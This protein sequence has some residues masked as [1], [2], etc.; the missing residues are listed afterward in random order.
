MTDLGFSANGPFQRMQA[1]VG[2]MKWTK[3]FGY[4]YHGYLLVTV[5]S[6]TRRTYLVAMKESGAK[7]VAE[8]FQSFLER[9]KKER[10]PAIFT[11]NKTK[12]INNGGNTKLEMLQLQT[13]R[14]G[15]FI[16]Q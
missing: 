2:N 13:D 11:T 14:G 16:I 3:Q 1:D 15:N 10:K 5:D 6:Y 12:K 8:A 9:I 7:D 4:Y